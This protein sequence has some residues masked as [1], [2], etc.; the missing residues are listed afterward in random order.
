[1]RGLSWSQ[2]SDLF[3]FAYRRLR[4]GRLPQVAGSLTFTTVLALVPVLTIALAIFTAFPL[5]NTF[6]TSLEAYFIQSL[7]PQAISN[8]ILGYLT[9]FAT[10]ATRLSAVGGVALMI[11]AVTTLGMIDRAFNQIWQVKRARP[12]T[13]SILVYWAIIT[14]GPLLIG[15][16]ITA[17]SYLFTATSGVVGSVPFIGGVFYTL[18]SVFFT[19]GAFTLLYLSVPNRSVDWRDAAWGGLFAAIAFEIAKRFFAIFVMRFPTYTVVYGALAA[20]PIF[21]IWIYLSWLITLIGAVIAA[22]LPIVKF[23]RWWHVSAP[24]S[25]F[26]D[27][28]AILKALLF[29]RDASDGAAVD[30]ATIRI[31]T[32]FGLDEIDGLLEK[33][34]EAGWVARV[35]GDLP[36]NAK[37]MLWKKNDLGSE[38]WVLLANPDQLTLADVYRM[39][40]FDVPA[41]I[42][43]AAKVGALIE[44]GLQECLSSY[45]AKERAAE[46]AKVQAAA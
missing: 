30:V 11:T 15:V 4:E 13:Q 29:A 22:A 35:S 6:R 3:V 46:A 44:Q 25:S 20:V 28:L 39:F 38:R 41:E 34:L 45:F 40:V 26:V 31:Q 10:K 33:M 19:T 8:N 5:F 16:S 14:L 2:I 21:L 9:Q 43:L 37:S 42:G 12:W 24:G 32:R 23:E 27:A 1:M 17:T 36:S 7:M 18:V